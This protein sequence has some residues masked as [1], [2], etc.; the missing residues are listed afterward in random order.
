MIG[1]CSALI[2][3]EQGAV[4]CELHLCYDTGPRFYYLTQRVAPFMI[5]KGILMTNSIL[6]PQGIALLQN[7]FQNN[8]KLLITQLK[9]NVYL[10]IS[11]IGKRLWPETPQFLDTIADGLIVQQL[12]KRTWP[13]ILD[14]VEKVVFTVVCI[15]LDDSIKLYVVYC[16]TLTTLTRTGLLMPKRGA[17]IRTEQ[18]ISA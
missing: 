2:S 10:C 7:F 6:H 13:I 3:Y 5:S 8:I 9:F 1:V 14:L 4:L 18:A 11:P 12:G 15:V 16:C 17:K